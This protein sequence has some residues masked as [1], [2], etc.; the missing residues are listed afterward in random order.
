MNKDDMI[1]DLCNARIMNVV[2]EKYREA[3]KEVDTL[4]RKREELRGILSSEDAK[5]IPMG[6]YTIMSTEYVSLVSRIDI[7]KKVR[8]TWD[9]AKEICRDCIDEIV[10]E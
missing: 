10:K 7:A 1:R 9:Q 8:D 2:R 6:E 5:N 4:T 3:S